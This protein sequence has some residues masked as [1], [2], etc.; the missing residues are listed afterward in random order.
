MLR[1]TKHTVIQPILLILLKCNNLKI[2]FKT[3]REKTETLPY[4]RTLVD[5]EDPKIIITDCVYQLMGAGSAG[6]G[7]GVSLCIS[8]SNSLHNAHSSP[9]V[10]LR[11]LATH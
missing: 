9:L 4:K 5:R 11:E 1:Q 7:R 6:R 2:S 8:G 10:S 3:K